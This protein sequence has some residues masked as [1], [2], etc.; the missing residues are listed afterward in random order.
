MK[1]LVGIALAAVL[2]FSMLGLLAAC[3]G[4]SDIETITV[5]TQ[6][7]NEVT[8]SNYEVRLKASVDWAS[9]SDSSREKIAKAGF[10]E[11][12]AKIQEDGVHNYNIIGITGDGGRAFMFDREHSLLI[13]FVN[14]EKVGEVAVE[15]PELQPAS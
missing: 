3:K 4:S 8:M 14:D 6:V 5:G 10:D 15:T 13:I 12:Q 11:A 2:A 1:K 7:S 9:L